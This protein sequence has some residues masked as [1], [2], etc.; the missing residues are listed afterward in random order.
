[1][2]SMYN[3]TAFAL[4]AD[5][6]ANLESHMRTVNIQGED[7]SLTQ[8]CVKD[9]DTL[10]KLGVAFAQNKTFKKSKLNRAISDE[11]YEYSMSANFGYD[12]CS[13]SNREDI[14]ID[15]RN[16]WEIRQDY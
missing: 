12:F 3:V 16:R 6:I 2:I 1:M 11:T 15:K 13:F 14:Y 8:L 9:R 10:N 4:N 7:E 5:Q